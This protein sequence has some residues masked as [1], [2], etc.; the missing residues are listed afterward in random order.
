MHQM[1][2]SPTVGGFKGN[3]WSNLTR[4]SYF[5]T[6]SL[7]DLL[8]ATGRHSVTTTVTGVLT[9][10]NRDCRHRVGLPTRVGEVGS[11]TQRL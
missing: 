10:G 11:A 4:S 5:S 1:I 8:P 9:K 6:G 7:N 3:L 2:P